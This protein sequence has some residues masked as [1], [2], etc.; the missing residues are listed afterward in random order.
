MHV[1]PWSA[2]PTLYARLLRHLQLSIF[3]I[4]ANL[5]EQKL[6]LYNAHA[7][8]ATSTTTTTHNATYNVK[9]LQRATY[10]QTH[11]LTTTTYNLQLNTST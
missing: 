5:I 10:Q 11:N 9:Q 2:L 3:A 7:M 8:D 6:Q 4:K 1:V